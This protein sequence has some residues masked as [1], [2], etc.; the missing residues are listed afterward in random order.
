MTNCE[1]RDTQ[2]PYQNDHYKSKG[3]AGGTAFTM[4]KNADLK[5]SLAGNNKFGLLSTGYLAGIK[6]F[7]GIWEQYKS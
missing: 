7:Q 2:C 5:I 3:F 1:Q 4:N 6:R